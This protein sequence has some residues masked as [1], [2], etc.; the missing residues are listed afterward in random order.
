MTYCWN[1][2]SGGKSGGFRCGLL[3][4]NVMFK[5]STGSRHIVVFES[6]EEALAFWN[7]N[8]NGLSIV[9]VEPPTRRFT[10]NQIV[11]L[12]C[13]P[14]MHQNFVDPIGKKGVVINAGLQPRTN[15]EFITISMIDE[16]FFKSEHHSNPGKL[17]LAAGFAC[18]PNELSPIS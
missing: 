14:A 4:N 13:I 2:Y 3:D 10:K 9:N 15:L 16:L 7:E 18:Y 1:Q 6:D 17:E 12:N 8:T 11:E 5:F